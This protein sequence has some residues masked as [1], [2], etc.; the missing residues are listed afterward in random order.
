MFTFFQ[1]STL[2]PS[3]GKGRGCADKRWGGNP[4]PQWG[5][6]GSVVWM[7]TRKRESPEVRRLPGRPGRQSRLQTHQGREPP[8]VGRGSRGCLADT[9]ILSLRAGGT[10]WDEQLLITAQLVGDADTDS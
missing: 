10:P 8:P 9:P 1:I 6:P 5:Q 3:S 4:N 7:L 2:P